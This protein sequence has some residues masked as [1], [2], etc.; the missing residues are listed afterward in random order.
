MPPVAKFKFL[1]EKK[2]LEG[3]RALTRKKTQAQ[4]QSRDGL[5][6]VYPG[7]RE[8]ARPAQI[9][10]KFQREREMNFRGQLSL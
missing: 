2:S 4:K 9:Q 5:F 1:G 3:E 10:K 7:E 8:R 6:S